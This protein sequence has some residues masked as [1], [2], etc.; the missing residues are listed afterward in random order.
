[1]P[2][3]DCNMK[4]RLLFFAVFSAVAASGAVLEEFTSPRDFTVWKSD[5]TGFALIRKEGRLALLRQ[6]G[7]PYRTEFAW[8]K[9][10]RLPREFRQG[11]LRLTVSHTVP[12]PQRT[13]RLRLSDV[14][15]EVFQFHSAAPVVH[16]DK[17]VY[18]F[19]VGDKQWRSSWGKNANKKIDYPLSLHV[20]AIAF[21]GTGTIV[22]EKLELV[23]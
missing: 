1:M 13:I 8:R 16:D 22:F 3:T 2:Y 23:D 19:Q 20:L 14:E 9:D 6:E 18:E 11:V 21:S 4:L 5:E 10:L 15:G 7:M 17:L 12:A